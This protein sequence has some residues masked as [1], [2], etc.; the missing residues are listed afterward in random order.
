MLKGF[1]HARLACG[2]RVGFREGV[3]GSPV[4]VVVDQKG[5]GLPADAAR[6]RSAALRS[7]RSAA[8]VDAA[9]AARRERIRRVAERCRLAVRSLSFFDFAGFPSPL[10]QRPPQ[11]KLDLAVEAAQIVVCPALNRVEH[12]A[13][14]PQQ[15][16]L[17]FGHAVDLYW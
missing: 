7:S 10:F 3:E 17:S 5:P 4:T 12:I 16:R 2:C 8:S 11:Q 14:D 13:V 6:A 15:E 1:T 9:A